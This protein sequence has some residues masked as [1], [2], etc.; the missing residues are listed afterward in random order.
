MPVLR[1]CKVFARISEA[2]AQ[3]WKCK[4]HVKTYGFRRFFVGRVLFE[5]GSAVEGNSTKKTARG[6]Q[7]GVQVALE[8]QFEAQNGVQVAIGGQFGAQNGVQVA[9]GGKFEG[10]NGVQVALGGQFR[11]QNGVQVALGG[12][13][14]GPSGLQAAPR[15]FQMEAKMQKRAPKLG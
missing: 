15:G 4:R 10:Q 1:F 11:S 12:Q 7:N 8:G 6:R 3:T 5:K 13:F 2:C 14:E 9:L